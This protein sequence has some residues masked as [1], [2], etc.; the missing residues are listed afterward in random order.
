MRNCLN[1]LK[2]EKVRWFV[3]GAVAI[4]LGKKVLKSDA[5]RNACVKTIAKAMKLQN[6]AAESFQNMREDAQD[7]CY[8]AKQA[9]GISTEEKEETEQEQA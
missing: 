4:V 3:G 1:C 6:D 9:A 2:S 5:T 7:L 8:D